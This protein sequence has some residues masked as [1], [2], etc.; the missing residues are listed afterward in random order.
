MHGKQIG[1]VYYVRA[2]DVAALL[3][4]NDVLPGIAAKLRAALAR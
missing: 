3:E 2:D 4:I 1:D